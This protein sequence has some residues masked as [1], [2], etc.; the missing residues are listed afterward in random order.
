MCLAWVG[1]MTEKYPFDKFS[2]DLQSAKIIYLGGRI[3]RITTAASIF[4]QKRQLFNTREIHSV[5]FTCS[6]ESNIA[7]P[8]I[9]SVRDEFSQLNNSGIGLVRQRQINVTPRVS[10]RKQVNSLYEISQIYKVNKI[11]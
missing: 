1:L 11:Y 6:P 8:N 7:C 5:F 2:L 4:Y 3:I 9:C 10:I